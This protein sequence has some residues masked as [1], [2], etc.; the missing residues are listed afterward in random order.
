M[1][2]SLKQAEE[3]TGWL[4]PIIKIH[5]IGPYSVVEYWHEPASNAEDKRTYRAF[6]T[7][8]DD[9]STHHS[10]GSFDEALA[11][12]VAIRHDGINTR[13]DRYFIRGIGA[14]V[15]PEFQSVAA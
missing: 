10:Y 7:Y 2:I 9:K 12:C 14:D 3:D 8:I 5:G 15:P 13:A 11:G 4:G 1:T 6:A